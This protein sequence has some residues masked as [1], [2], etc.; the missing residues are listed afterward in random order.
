MVEKI[1]RKIFLKY[2]RSLAGKKKSQPL[3][4]WLHSQSLH[5]M[6]YGSGAFMNESGEQHA[7]FHIK[8]IL[9]K[10]KFP[11]VLFDVGAN[12]GHFTEALL[13]NFS[14]I[15]K[16]IHA[17]EPSE[18]TFKK[19]SENISKQKDVKLNNFG[20]GHKNTILQLYSDRAGSGIASVYKRNLEHFKINM[21]ISEEI[22]IK[23]IDSYCSENNI[24]RIHF[25]KLDIEGN[26]LNALNGAQ[27]MIG[28]NAID[29]IQF[30]FGGCNID[31]RTYFQDF[32]Y[33]LSPQYT[34]YRIVNEGIYP[35]NEYRESMEVFLTT[36]YL[37][38]RK[39]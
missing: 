36:N 3:F 18:T 17:F 25:L 16:Q 29:F 39:Q 1:F 6:N 15:E 33:L 27:D 37:A 11:L 22:E 31:S 23:T 10:E 4:E 26:E 7:L 14:A 19:L 32:Y 34:I 13:K 21:N 5:G 12:V 28:K 38:E 2:T 35:V 24:S 9:N 8:K 20:I 30:E